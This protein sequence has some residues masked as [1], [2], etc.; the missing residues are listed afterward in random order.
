MSELWS[1]FHARWTA[2]LACS[3]ACVRTEGGRVVDVVFFPDGSRAA[4]A[5]DN[6]DPEWF[7]AASLRDAIEITKERT[8]HCTSVQVGASTTDLRSDRK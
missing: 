5:I 4:Y 2:G 8:E 1:L 3:Y 7:D 6:S